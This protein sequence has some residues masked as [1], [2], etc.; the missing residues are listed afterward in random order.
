MELLDKPIVLRLNRVWQ[1]VGVSTVRDALVAMNSGDDFVRAAVGVDVCYSQNE[2]GSWDLENPNLVPTPFEK[3]V[4]LP[5]REFD[6]VIHTPKLL[7]RVPTV[8]IAMNYSK[9]H[10]VRKHP[11]KQNV[12]ERDQNCCQITGRLLSKK[13]GNI[14][15]VVPRSRGGRDTWENLIWMDKKLNSEKG[16]RTLQEMGWKTIRKPLAPKEIPV[17]ATI[18]NLQHGDWR[19]FIEN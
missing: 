5:V 16:D 18:K 14:D 8:I 1:A 15:H 12:R 3:W 2:D 7:I 9:Q 11:T 19:F 13:E 6:E 17:S 4:Q 10:K